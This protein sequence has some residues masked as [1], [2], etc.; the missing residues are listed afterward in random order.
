MISLVVTYFSKGVSLLTYFTPALHF[1][2]KPGTWFAL[3]NKWLV[4]IWNATLGCNGKRYKWNSL[5]WVK[6]FKIRIQIFNRLLFFFSLKGKLAPEHVF[7]PLILPKT[8]WKERSDVNF[9]CPWKPELKINRY[10]KLFS[11]QL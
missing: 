8:I 7:D 9:Y 1:M 10:L 3:Q 11:L 4:S 2:L 6:H 5:K